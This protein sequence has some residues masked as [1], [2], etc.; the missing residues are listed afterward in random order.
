VL[1]RDPIRAADRSLTSTR[2][3]TRFGGEDFRSTLSYPANVYALPGTG[4]LPGLNAPF[5]AVPAGT[6]GIGLTAAD[7]STTAGTLDLFNDAPYATL[8]AQSD[9]QSLFA[10]GSR[11][12][13]ASSLEVFGEMLY[14]HK[15]QIV[16]QGP[17]ALFGGAAGLFIVPA[18]NPFNPFGAPVGVD[19]RFMELGPRA[20]DSS[21]DFSRLLIGARGG[22]FRR[23]S[24]D[25]YV[26]ADRDATAVTNRGAVN[27][28][29]AQQFLNST[30]P[31]TALNVFST[32]GN[33]NPDTLH[34]IL[35]ETIDNL[36]TQ[37]RMGEATLR[38]PLMDLPA[39]PLQFAIG[40]NMRRE[41]LAFLSP[42]A[43]NIRSD[44]TTKAAFAEVSLPLIGA[45]QA[46]PGVRSL[47]LTGAARY[48]DYAREGS[49]VS[50][51]FGLLWR[52]VSTLLVRAS[53]GKAF[54][55]ATPFDLFFPQLTLPTVVADPLRNG[56]PSAVALVF[57]GKPHLAPEKGD[58]RTFGIKWEPASA[59]GFSVAVSAF[60]VEQRDFITRFSDTDLLLNNADQFPGRVVRAPATPEDIALGLPGRLVSIDQSSVNF[61]RIVVRGTDAQ[62]EYALQPMRFGQFVTTVS[63]TY[64]DDYEVLLTPGSRP[65]N[66]V[67]QANDAGYPVRF[68]GG[69]ALSWS[70]FDSWSAALS[71]RYLASYTDYDGERRL[72]A[73]R[74]FDF[75]V[76]HHFGARAAAGSSGWD[77]T[78]GILNLTD[79]QGDFSNNL[80]GYD[81]HQADIRGRYFYAMLKV[82]F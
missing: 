23:F 56:E 4:N 35:D 38:G 71:G 24:W 54:K 22:L 51:Q 44:R 18:D 61:G 57:G 2:D 74:W 43:G 20:N 65:I 9:R 37:A 27:R 60:R 1:D 58:S 31:Q 68:K 19:Y 72:P 5:A 64:I 12:F 75:Q 14:T 53:R 17:D 15:H 25:V 40:V 33:N 69:A 29:I 47:E 49:R 7:F 82:R 81:P 34:A 39:G 52:P 13:S 30:D 46:M 36:T 10:T 77:A 28:D 41:E 48:D 73:Q 42:Q 6:D 62:F 50:P 45:A 63:G 21:T 66:R 32:T 3:F 11:R 76:N 70:G 59:P 67:S 8:E 16:Q 26:L 55:L 78:L 79:N 80:N